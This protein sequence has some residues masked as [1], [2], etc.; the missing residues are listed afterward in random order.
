MTVLPLAS[1]PLH[2]NLYTE[3]SSGRSI[4]IFKLKDVQLG[5]HSSFYPRVE[6]YS[7][8]TKSWHNPICE[9]TMS[10]SQSRNSP[11]YSPS[12]API[13]SKESTPL[14]F[15]IYSTD[16][17][18]HFVYDSLPYLISFKHLQKSTPN[19]KL[20]MSYPTPSRNSF[21]KFNLEFLEL[22]GIKKEDIVIA[23]PHNIYSTLLISESYTHGNNSN[24]PPRSEIYRLY[25]GLKHKCA[26]LTRT[27]A[28]SPK[29]YIS[30]RSGSCRDK[31]NAGTDY[32]QRR[33]LE[34]EDEVVD[35]FKSL[36]FKEVFCENLS[37][38]DKINLF[39]NASHIAGAIGGGLCN[40]LFSKPSVRLLALV[41]PVFL[42]VN[43]RFKYSFSN[44]DTEYFIDSSHTESSQVKTNMRVQST[45][46]YN[47][48]EITRLLPDGVFVKV[49]KNP[50][51]GWSSS[52]SYFEDFWKH[53][54]YVTLDKGLNSPWEVDINSLEIYVDKWYNNR[55]DP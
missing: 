42:E 9:K 1:A 43:E 21:Y 45:E 39:H 11:I 7:H 24:A 34:N 6:A 35:R 47:L 38:V 3:D 13:T 4:N 2:E 29:I 55:H 23:N 54:T 51:A 16:N 40:A 20:L 18:Y 19:L 48:G 15:F 27:P 52:E 32:T 31:A 22:A 8:H 46:S 26:L 10:L 30:R 41:S 50:V 17:Y 44:V 37:T 5:R 28:Y 12:L 49:A 33:K 53:G 25:Q 14:F 36:G